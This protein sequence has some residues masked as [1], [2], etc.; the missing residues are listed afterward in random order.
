VSGIEGLLDGDRGPREKKEATMASLENAR[1]TID[2]VALGEIVD[3][4]KF[5]DGIG[6]LTDGVRLCRD[7]TTR[8]K[9]T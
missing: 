2:A 8:A 3:P 4:E 9:T 7:A 1:Q 6:L 5:K